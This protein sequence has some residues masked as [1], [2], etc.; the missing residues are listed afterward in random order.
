MIH[1]ADEARIVP[2]ETDSQGLRRIGDLSQN[3][4][5]TK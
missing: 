2:V 5:L 4:G 1:S 3:G